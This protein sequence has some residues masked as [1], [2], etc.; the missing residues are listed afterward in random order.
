MHNTNLYDKDGVELSAA[1]VFENLSI[2]SI[3]RIEVIDN[4]GRVYVNWG[5]KDYKMYIQDKERTLKVYIS[6]KDVG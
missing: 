3:S 5:I 1:Q 6:N 2:P 4:T